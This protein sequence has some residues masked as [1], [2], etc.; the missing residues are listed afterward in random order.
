MLNGFAGA[1]ASTEASGPPTDQ[2]PTFQERV[3][4]FVTSQWGDLGYLFGEEAGAAVPTPLAKPAPDQLEP[5]VYASMTQGLTTAV[6]RPD[7]TPTP[8]ATQGEPAATWTFADTLKREAAK[9]Q[10]R[11]QA[12]R[13]GG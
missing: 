6:P 3:N 10:A 8:V 5:A 4:T 1:N 11:L 13:H 12:A 9:V 7:T 2:G